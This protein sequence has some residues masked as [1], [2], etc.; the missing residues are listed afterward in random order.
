MKNKFLLSAILVVFS[1]SLFAQMQKNKGY[2]TANP[3]L[4]SEFVNPPK[5][6]GNIPFYW[7]SGDRLNK[8]RL[9][10]QLKIL[11]QSATDGFSVSYI[12]TDPEVDSVFNKNGYGLFGRTSPGDPAV[13]S[14]DW[15]NIWNWY[16][17]ECAQ[18]GL[19]V[20]LD[21]Y[22]IGWNG[23]GYYPD[24]LDTMS[25]FQNYQGKLVIDSYS[26]N[27]GELFTCRLPE[28]FLSA[29]TWPGRIDLSGYIHGKELKWKAPQTENYKIYVIHTE[30][31]YVLHPL[32][33]KKLVDV[34]FDRFYHRMDSLSREGMNYFF[35][36]EL[37]Y[38]INMLSWSDDF[39]QEFQRRKGYDVIP[40]LSALKEYIGAVTP[41]IRLDYA[42][43]LISLA[44]ERYFEPIYEVKK[45]DS[46]VGILLS[47]PYQLDITPYMKE[48]N[49]K[50]E[51]LV[52]ST[53]ANHYQTI[54]T[55]PV[56]YTH[57]T[58]PTNS[59]V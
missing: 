14:E 57:L 48:G 58:L 46:L 24:E 35:Q 52:Y 28:R 21:D 23:N 56:S 19:G 36:D 37:S 2:P 55:P 38:P 54:P 49:N 44:E 17:G 22:T 30:N 25:V 10:E 18:L 34:Y 53:L 20:G 26:V 16:S 39:P 31:S 32:H 8:E 42:D 11:S 15:W 43:V 45:N 50:M 40:Y 51:I 41:K 6:Y 7:W 3:D 27:K 13:F 1:V 4:R 47:L 29:V 59:R 33:G 12:H 9:K 5:G